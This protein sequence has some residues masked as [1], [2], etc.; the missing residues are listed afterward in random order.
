M[1][2]KIILLVV[3]LLG[4]GASLF[5]YRNGH[6]NPAWSEMKGVWWIPL[7]LAIICLVLGLLPGAKR[8]A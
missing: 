2:K 1:A 6:T 8:K 4:F 7:P 5:M 3:A